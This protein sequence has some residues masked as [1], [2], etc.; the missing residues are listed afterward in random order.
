MSWAGIVRVV[1][2]V[3]GIV[4]VA[5]QAKARGAS[6]LEAIAEGASAAVTGAAGVHMAQPGYM[7]KK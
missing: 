1:M 6:T 2:F 5:V 3:G 7:T 4:G